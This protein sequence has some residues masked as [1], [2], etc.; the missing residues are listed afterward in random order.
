MRINGSSSH[1]EVE[2]RAGH[3]NAARGKVGVRARPSAVR[4]GLTTTLPPSSAK[5]L[6]PVVF[7]A[8]FRRDLCGEGEAM[9]D[10]IE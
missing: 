3:R 9:D 4:V 10:E 5:A 8:P 1:C 2:P 6:L 7:L